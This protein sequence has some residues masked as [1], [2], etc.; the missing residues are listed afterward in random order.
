[1]RSAWQSVFRRG[2]EPILE[3]VNRKAAQRRDGQSG[4]GSRFGTIAEASRRAAFVARVRPT[5]KASA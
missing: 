1:M 4:S 2:L 3:A 5:V